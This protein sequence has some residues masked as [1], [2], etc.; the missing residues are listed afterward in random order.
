MAISD[1][2]C[3]EVVFIRV[4]TGFRCWEK[5]SPFYPRPACCKAKCSSK[6]SISQYLLIMIGLVRE[7][8]YVSAA[9]PAVRIKGESRSVRRDGAFSGSVV[10]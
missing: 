3:E 8:K 6:R 10:F 5:K 1:G 2:L 4:I 9:Y 7:N